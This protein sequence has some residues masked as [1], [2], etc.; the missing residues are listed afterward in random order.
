MGRHS[1]Y[2]LTLG[3]KRTHH[4][5]YCGLRVWGSGNSAHRCRWITV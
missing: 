1:E 5:M 3:S 4:E 2:Q